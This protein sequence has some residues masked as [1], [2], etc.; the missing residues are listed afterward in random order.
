M[1]GAGIYKSVRGG[2]LKGV[3]REN[4]VAEGVRR[5]GVA[6]KGTGSGLFLPLSA[7]VLCGLCYW[8]CAIALF[9]SKK[10]P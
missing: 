10:R 4:I 8:L 5:G 2:S 6:V 9:K 3:T 1:A 7:V